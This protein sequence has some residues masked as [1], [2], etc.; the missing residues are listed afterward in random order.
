[1]SKN[2][3]ILSERADEDLEEIFEF[4]LNKFGFQQAEKYLFE[5]ENV[6]ETLYKNPSLGKK[7]NEIK[8]G[9]LSFPKDNHIVFYRILKNRIWIVRVL[10]GSRDIPNYF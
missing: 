6:F 1:M 3:Y 10:H 9:L 4:T 8:N 2:H 5:L 7:R